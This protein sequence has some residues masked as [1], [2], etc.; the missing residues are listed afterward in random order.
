VSTNL[1]E[2]LA[3]ARRDGSRDCETTTDA[4]NPLGKMLGDENFFPLLQLRL[5]ANS[6][7]LQPV[8]A[9]LDGANP[10]R[11]ASPYRR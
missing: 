4:N 2:W 11:S 10:F 1:K 9:I 3:L 5:S 6:V 7:P 8:D